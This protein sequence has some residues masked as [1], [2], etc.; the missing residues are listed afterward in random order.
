[1]GLTFCKLVIENHDGKIGIGKSD[2]N[3]TEFCIYMNVKSVTEKKIPEITTEFAS[4][5]VL[6]KKEIKDL[7][8]VLE[9]LSK[10]DFYE[11]SLII[12]ELNKI[13][14]LNSENI[15]SWA[16]KVE[17]AVFNSNEENYQKL[18]KQN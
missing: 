12:A 17:N 5:V 2:K 8:P 1:L 11:S 4:S 16:K 3:G 18:I 6:N 13:E 7:K 15:E 14:T 9:K 10:I